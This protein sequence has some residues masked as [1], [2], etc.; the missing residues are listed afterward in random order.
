MNQIFKLFMVNKEPYLTIDEEVSV[1]DTAIVTVGDQ[2]PSVVECKND[3]QIN[4]FQRPNTSLTKR[5]K[6]V[7]K[8]SEISLDDSVIQ[9]LL[10]ND[11][12]V[13]VEYDNGQI[14]FIE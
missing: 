1:G 6:V 10:L 4:I 3:D 11:M 9:S 5:Y 7:M 8:P 12:P 13:L 2:Y 14:N